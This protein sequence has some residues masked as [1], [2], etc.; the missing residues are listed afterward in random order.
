VPTCVF[1]VDLSFVVAVAIEVM[2]LKVE[3]GSNKACQP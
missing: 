1:N 2:L 3:V